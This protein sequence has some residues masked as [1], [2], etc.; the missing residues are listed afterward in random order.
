MWPEQIP[1]RAKAHPYFARRRPDLNPSTVCSTYLWGE[2]RNQK[3]RA[4]SSSGVPSG[5]AQKEKGKRKRKGKYKL[6]LYA[7]VGFCNGV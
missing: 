4:R 5:V 7:I 2:G 6:P 3:H 1:Q